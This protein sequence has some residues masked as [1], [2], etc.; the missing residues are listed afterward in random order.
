MSSTMLIPSTDTLVAFLMVFTRITATL[1]ILPVFGAQQ[2]P[3]RYKAAMGAA[4]SVMILVMMQPN[5]QIAQSGGGDIVLGFVSEAVL[6][7]GLGFF[8]R[9]VI[10][11]VVL[12]ASI[13]GFQMGFAIV[14]VIDPQSGDN[15][16]LVGSFQGLVA[17]MVFIVSG[18]Y[19]FFLTGLLESFY[20]VPPGMAVINAESGKLF[21]EAGGQLFVTAVSVA[22]PVMLSLFIAKVALGIVARTVPQMNIF[23]VGM[24]LTIGM[25]LVLMGLTLPFMVEMTIHALNQS[26]DLYQAYI[27][28]AAP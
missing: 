15:I 7:I 25:G 23:I 21:Y 24:P 9:L 22:A 17:G 1:S 19:R 20:I 26:A 16:S 28:S 18:M 11:A 2:I 4:I 5:T 8:V 27:L 14:N 3:I 13:V 6:G 10:E 12:G